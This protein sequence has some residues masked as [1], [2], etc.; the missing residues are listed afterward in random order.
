[1]ARSR[2]TRLRAVDVDDIDEV[3]GGGGNAAPKPSANPEPAPPKPAASEPTGKSENRKE[4]TKR[5]ASKPV[6]TPDFSADT[7][8]L[9]STRHPQ[10]VVALIEDL[11]TE[12]KQR[13]RRITKQDVITAIVWERLSG[14]TS[15]DREQIGRRALEIRT[16]RESSSL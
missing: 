13:N 5:A 4:S 11:V 16:S 9:L 10:T 15:K 14:A 8:I 3:L 12:L 7:E 6:Q 2:S 1:M